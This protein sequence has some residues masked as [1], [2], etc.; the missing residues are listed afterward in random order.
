MMNAGDMNMLEKLG[1]HAQNFSG[2]IM[3]VNRY[4]SRNKAMAAAM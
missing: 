4:T 2:R 3:A 1:L